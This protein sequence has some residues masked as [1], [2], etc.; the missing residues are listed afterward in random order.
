VTLPE[1]LP[2]GAVTSVAFHGDRAI[3]TGAGPSNVSYLLE[4]D[5]GDWSRITAE[6]IDGALY[7]V[8]FTSEG[9]GVAVGAAPSYRP[10]VLDER[11]SWTP[12]EVLSNLALLTHVGAGQDGVIRSVGY[13]PPLRCDGPGEWTTE[14]VIFPGDPGDKGFLDL[15]VGPGGSLYACAFDDGGEGTPEQ[16]YRMIMQNDGSGW[17][18]VA[19]IPTANA[20]ALAY[21]PERGFIAAGVR[22]QSPGTS[23]VILLAVRAADGQWTEFELPEQPGFWDVQDILVASDDHVYVLA[24]G[25]GDI[26]VDESSGSGLL[27][28]WDGETFK[29]M[30]LWSNR[31]PFSLAEG[32]TGLFVVGMDYR[33][34]TSRPWMVRR[35]L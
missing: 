21:D 3:A 5:G 26:E 19:P 17:S 4:S 16:P 24:E 30:G 34:G 31:G 13:G 2:D 11:E 10:L 29:Q 12:T 28:R 23:S 27:W 25:P 6:D 9:E 8:M 18:M 7:D 33:S 22:Y 35:S 14:S 20:E 32:P 15:C 1:G